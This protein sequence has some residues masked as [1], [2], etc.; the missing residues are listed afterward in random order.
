MT[1]NVPIGCSGMAPS[2]PGRASCTTKW[3]RCISLIAT[4]CQVVGYQEVLLRPG[5]TFSQLKSVCTSKVR[6]ALPAV[7]ST[8]ATAVSDFL[9]AGAPELLRRTSSKQAYLEEQ[10]WCPGYIFNNAPVNLLYS[11]QRSTFFLPCR[12]C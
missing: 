4:I 2:R 11:L 6:D 5:G 9:G 12:I 10:V 8:R 1:K 7:A 3:S